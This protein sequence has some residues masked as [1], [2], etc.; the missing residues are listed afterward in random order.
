MRSSRR[1]DNLSGSRVDRSAIC[2]DSGHMLWPNLLDVGNLS[3]A[4]YA[5][6]LV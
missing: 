1:S 5:A 2:D 6:S 3:P 4:V